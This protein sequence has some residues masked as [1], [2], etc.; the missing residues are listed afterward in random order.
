MLILEINRKEEGRTIAVLVLLFDLVELRPSLVFGG[1]ALH[2]D[3]E[4][5]AAFLSL[6][7]L[8]Q[9][10]LLPVQFGDDVDGVVFFGA[11]VVLVIFLDAVEDPRQGED[12]VPDVLGVVG[13]Q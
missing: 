13:A 11:E 8:N 5:E 2:E 12:Q 7:L 3:R 9:F 4:A 1:E 6:H 10:L